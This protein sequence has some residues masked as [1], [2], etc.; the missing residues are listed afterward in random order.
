MQ[1]TTRAPPRSGVDFD[2]EKRSGR[3]GG[4]GVRIVPNRGEVARVYALLGN[5]KKPWVMGL[6]RVSF[7][8]A[9]AIDGTVQHFRVLAMSSKSQPKG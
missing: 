5:G 3:G 2:R 6:A 7:S 1:P 9:N 8:V 4:R